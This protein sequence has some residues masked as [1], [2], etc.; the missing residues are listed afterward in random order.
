MVDVPQMPLETRAKVAT[1][2]EEAM[3]NVWC[4]P[5]LSCA[6]RFRVRGICRSAPKLIENVAMFCDR[7][8][9]IQR[10]T[11]AEHSGVDVHLFLH[12][13]TTY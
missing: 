2:G 5:T 6:R 8:G 4:V 9:Q 1:G 3:L 13:S 12:T 7:D 10:K 11:I